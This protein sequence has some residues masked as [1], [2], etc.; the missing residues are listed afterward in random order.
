MIS[1]CM[2]FMGIT[3]LMSLI[4]GFMRFVEFEMSVEFKALSNPYYRIGVSFLEYTTEEEEF[5]EQEF[6]LSLFFIEVV[7][8]F[9]KEKEA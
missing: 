3:I 7:L 8:I 6:R 9:H 5:I 4:T 2:V 1:I